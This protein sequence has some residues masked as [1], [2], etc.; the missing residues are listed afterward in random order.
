MFAG[1]DEPCGGETGE[2]EASVIVAVAVIPH[3]SSSSRSSGS[4][5]WADE[6]QLP[7]EFRIAI[8]PEGKMAFRSTGPQRRWII[9]YA[10]RDGSQSR[11]RGDP[12]GGAQATFLHVSEDRQSDRNCLGVVVE[13]YGNRSA[14]NEGQRSCWALD[15]GR[16]V[17]ESCQY[18]TQEGGWVV[19]RRTKG[20]LRM[21]PAG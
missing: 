2:D 6:N 11:A 9:R 16:V 7:K 1:G 14:S 3:S 15:N 20:W 8:R 19:K 13:G 21:A 10:G 5:M 12:A 4:K 18:Q 17:D